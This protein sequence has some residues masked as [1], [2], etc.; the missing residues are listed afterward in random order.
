[1]TS[2][3]IHVHLL[4]ELQRDRTRSQSVRDFLNIP[5]LGPATPGLQFTN[6]PDR[7]RGART[8]DRSTMTA[9]LSSR[10]EGYENR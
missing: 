9:T 4:S 3:P 10:R 6:D 1:M 8:Q 7:A 5:R 2:L